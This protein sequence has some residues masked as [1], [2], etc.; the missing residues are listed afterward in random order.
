MEH[1]AIIKGLSRQAKFA[2]LPMPYFLGVMF[3]SVLPFIVFKIMA[4]L[5]TAPLWYIAARI[6]TAINPNLHRIWLI[7][8]SK[9]PPRFRARKSGRRYVC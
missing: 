7:K 1:A 8:L 3:L 6:T 2:G 4:W 9:T 5:L